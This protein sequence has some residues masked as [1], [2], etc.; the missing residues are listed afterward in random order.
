MKIKYFISALALVSLLVLS[1]C[2]NP[3]RYTDAREI[4]VSGEERVRKNIEEGRG[5]TLFGGDV[6]ISGSLYDSVGNLIAGGSGGSGVIASGSFNVPDPSEF[7]TTASLSLA[8]GLG[9]DYTA[10]SQGNLDDA[11]ALSKIMTREEI[12]ALIAERTAS[13][14]SGG[15]ANGGG[16]NRRGSGSKGVRV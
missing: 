1:A 6:V 10:D 13:A 5:V 11:M 8:G 14:A 12:A 3:F 4:P 15:S 9:F 7:V 2:K 16:P